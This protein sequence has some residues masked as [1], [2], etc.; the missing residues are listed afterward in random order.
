MSHEPKPSKPNYFKYLLNVLLLAGLV[1]SGYWA[2]GYLNRYDAGTVT[3][4]AQVEAYISPLNT[5]I[6]GYIKRIGFSEH[7]AVHR[8]DTLLVI[9]DR[10]L[11]IQVQQAEAAYLEAKA[12]ENVTSSAINTVRNNVDVADANLVEVRVRLANAEQNYHRYQRL[13]ADES[14]SRQQLEQIQTEYEALK[15]KYEAVLTQR[16]SASYATSEV[17]QRLGVNA[18]GIK[19]AEAA[20]AMARLNLSYTVITAPYD[21]FM[22]RRQIQDGQLLQ[23]GQA[24]ATIVRG[25]Q[26]WVTAN[27]R[28]TQTAGLHVGQP[29][30]IKVDALNGKVFQGKVAAIS[31]ATGAR[32]SAVPTDNATGNFVKVQQRI[33]VRIELSPEN[34][35][36]EVELL[37]AGMNV[38]VDAK[39]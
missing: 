26:K 34:P 15:A 1:F 10:E 21:G 31:Q 12:G 8:G 5:R 14:A 32:Y 19:R 18:A 28:E 36:A 3:N 16:K 37:R 13:V 39:I 9:D 27:Y 24:L 22:G 20:L 29:V 25:D 38:E 23:P 33:P 30:T 7:Q 35:A 11:R 17:R 4:D 2:Y 6:G